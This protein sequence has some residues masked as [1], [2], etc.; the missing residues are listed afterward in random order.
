M[1][2]RITK[3]MQDVGDYTPDQA[4]QAILDC[5]ESYLGEMDEIL[6]DKTAIQW[7]A[8]LAKGLQPHK[9]PRYHC[10]VCRYESTTRFPEGCPQCGTG[11]T[12]DIVV[13]P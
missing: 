13:K 4:C 2:D 5:I 1:D 9:V 3:A 7:A 11:H 6:P 12:P 8:I 10:K